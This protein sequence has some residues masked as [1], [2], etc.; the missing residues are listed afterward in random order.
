MALQVQCQGDKEKQ[1]LRSLTMLTCQRDCVSRHE[2]KVHARTYRLKAASY[3]PVKLLRILKCS[4]TGRS[5][6]AFHVS[7][8]HLTH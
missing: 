1:P 7:L 8:V 4:L 3:P 5:L 6:S 2:K